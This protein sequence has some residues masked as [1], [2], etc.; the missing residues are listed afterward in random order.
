MNIVDMYNENWTTKQVVTEA[1]NRLEAQGTRAVS[2]EGKLC[3][4]SEEYYPDTCLYYVETASGPLMCAVGLLLPS[5]EDYAELE[6]DVD[7]LRENIMSYQDDPELA[8]ALDQY[9]DALKCLQVFHDR[10]PAKSC[11][12]FLA[13]HS[14]RKVCC[15]LELHY[16]IRGGHE[17]EVVHSCLRNIK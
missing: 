6:G 15:L 4:H 2:E 11:L 3:Q 10:Q 8:D 14:N 7:T 9:R 12:Q 13:G 1:L 17:D 16:A 5:P